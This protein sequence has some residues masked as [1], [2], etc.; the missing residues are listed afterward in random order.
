MLAILESFFSSNFPK[1]VN[2][3]NAVNIENID[4]QLMDLIVLVQRILLILVFNVRYFKMNLFLELKLISFP[5][6]ALVD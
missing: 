5:R 4:A 1:F 2:Y 6:Q 3:Q